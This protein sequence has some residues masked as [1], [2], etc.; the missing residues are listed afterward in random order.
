MQSASIGAARTSRTASAG[1]DFRDLVARARIRLGGPIVLVWDSVRLHLTA[2]MKEFIDANADWL[3]VF[4]LP[5]YAPDRNPTEGIWA[6]VKRALGNLA[7]ADLG[8]ITRCMRARR[9]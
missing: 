6:L 5:A 2:R 8:E 3:T 7:A 4:Q 9:W 1:Q